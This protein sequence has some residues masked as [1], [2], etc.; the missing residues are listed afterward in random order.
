MVQ[1]IKPSVNIG[2]LPHWCD[3]TP[4]EQLVY[5]AS[6]RAAQSL[7]IGCG[8][9]IIPE[10]EKP[11]WSCCNCPDVWE[12]PDKYVLGENRSDRAAHAAKRLAARSI[13]SGCDR[14][15]FGAYGALRSAANG[16]TPGMLTDD[17]GNV[18]YDPDTELPY[19]NDRGIVTMAAAVGHVEDPNAALRQALTLAMGL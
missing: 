18:L 2:T 4:L 17:N 1:M 9:T 19:C 3:L 6:W 16:W 7:C 5:L 11:G 12:S 10:G 13:P 14:P 8:V 15:I